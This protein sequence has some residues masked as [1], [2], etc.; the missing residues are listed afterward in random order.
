MVTYNEDDGRIDEFWTLA[1]VKHGGT[2]TS[3]G[4]VSSLNDF[5]QKST[6]TG[7]TDSL[8]GTPRKSARDHSKVNMHLKVVWFD[9]LLV[10]D[11]VLVWSMSLYRYFI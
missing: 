9:V 11:E 1:S 3:R 2:P 10:D 6:A 5:S 8:G 4:D 7:H